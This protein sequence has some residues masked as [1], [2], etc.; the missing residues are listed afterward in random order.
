MALIN[1]TTRMV[2]VLSF[3]CLDRYQ[4]G[5]ERR[6]RPN[7]MPSLKAAWID[8]GDILDHRCTVPVQ[9]ERQRS[10]ELKID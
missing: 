3:P 2:G 7:L 1:Q 8:G 5:R 9:R 6:V 10:R 4:F